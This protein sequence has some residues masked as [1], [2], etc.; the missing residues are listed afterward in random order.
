MPISVLIAEDEP[1][2]LTLVKF[3]LRDA[4]FTVLTAEDGKKALEIA[5][6]DRPDIILLDVMMPFLNGYEVL[7]RLKQDERLKDIPVIMLT[8]KSFQ[9]EVDEAISKGATD[10]II[11]PFSPGDLIDRIRN[12]VNGG[13]TPS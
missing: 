13:P 4:G 9:H 6:S 5:R 7:E 3:K 11:K 10:Y 2:I 12:I 8:A 1:H